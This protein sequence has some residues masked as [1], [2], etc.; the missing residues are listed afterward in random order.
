[1]NAT[2]N[3]G[4]CRHF[5]RNSQ[6]RGIAVCRQRP[7]ER[8]GWPIVRDDDFCGAFSSKTEGDVFDI[9]AVSRRL[10]AGI[11]D[12]LERVDVMSDRKLRA[13]LDELIADLELLS[14]SAGGAA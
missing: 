11:N 4:A 8:A 6:G 3:C 14:S 9:A 7:P 12:L 10:A 2:N 5:D 13:D 1:M